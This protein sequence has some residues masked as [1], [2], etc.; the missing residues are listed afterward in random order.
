MTPLLE[1]RGLSKAFGSTGKNGRGA[2]RAV[3]G[4]DLTLEAGQTL[5]LV[6]ESGCGKT[7]LGRLVVG[8][9]TP[10]SG[11][12]R[13][14]GSDIF[15]MSERELRRKRREFQ[16]VFQDP[17]GSLDPR[18][19]VEQILL[20]PFQV[21]GLG[22]ETER[23]GWVA[24]LLEAVALDAADGARQARE[25]SGGQQ[26]RVGIARALALRPRLL[27]ADEPVAALD[28]SVAA[29]ILNLLSELQARY[30]LALLVISH[31]LPVVHYL[32]TRVAVMYAGRI[33]EEGSAAE[34]FR[35]P[36]HPYTRLLVQSSSAG[37]L[38]PAPADAPAARFSA[39]QL[40]TSVNPSAEPAGCSFHPRCPDAVERCRAEKPQ[41]AP[42]GE[43]GQVACFLY[44]DSAS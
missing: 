11:S 10:T 5:G 31:S 8:L 36:R 2:I 34:L 19:T 9:V 1:V 6:G 32:A 21:Q 43:E 42:R 18:H 28:A 22:T 29:Q 14:D 4:V 38:P 35:A 33:V 17:A 15:A 40:A 23:R 37:A 39:G 13:I 24:E 12:V 3:D 20:E 44:N 16:M 25:L 26:Q 41:L 30:G 27:V 7:T